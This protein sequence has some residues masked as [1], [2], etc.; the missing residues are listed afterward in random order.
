MQADEIRK[1]LGEVRLRRERIFSERENL[2]ARQQVD[3]ETEGTD[4]RL[5][6]LNRAIES[7]DEQI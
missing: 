3:G 6:N 2:V 7:A 1:E 4:Q 5:G